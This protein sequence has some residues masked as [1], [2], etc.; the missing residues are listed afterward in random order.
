MLTIVC[1]A[2]GRSFAYAGHRGH[3]PAYCSTACRSDARRNRVQ[4]GSGTCTVAGC[5]K[6][7]RPS[8][9]QVCEMH[10]YR[11]R[12]T[13][14]YDDAPLLQSRLNSDGYVMVRRP[15]HPLAAMAGSNRVWV[16]EQ[17]I[18]LYDAIGPGAHAC[19][20][21]GIPVRWDRSYPVHPDA[22]VAAHINGRITDNRAA[23]LTPVCSN[24]QRRYMMEA[25]AGGSA[26]RR[27]RLR[28]RRCV[29]KLERAARGTTGTYTWTSLPCTVCG[30]VFCRR[31]VPPDDPRRFC[32]T[33]CSRMNKRQ[34]LLEAGHRR[35]TRNRAA[36]VATVDRM[37]VFE[38]E[39]WKCHICG[40]PVK[41]GV[42]PRDPLAASIDHIVP[43]SKGGT[44][45]P[46][47]V[48]LAHMGC[49]GKRGARGG[50]EQFALF[51]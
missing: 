46:S 41:R 51:V 50:G 37:K 5:Q 1:R 2:C 16:Y 13:G 18:V 47:N 34:K 15:D 35:R 21:C 30:R 42:N 49:N 22:L 6:R 23:N 40:R 44:H 31:W 4:T 25:D 11:K 7:A 39:G 24:C 14:T 43:I 3:M 9:E 17:R 28:R 20:R 45:E 29:K 19:H 48:R 38:A 26:A 10:Y 8:K 12:R 33:E 32:S 36:F 27:A